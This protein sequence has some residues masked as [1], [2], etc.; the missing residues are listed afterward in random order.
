MSLRETLAG[1]IVNIGL[2]GVITEAENVARGMVESTANAAPISDQ[3]GGY[4]HPNL[5]HGKVTAALVK[6]KAARKDAKAPG[7]L[8]AKRILSPEARRRIQDAQKRRWDKEKGRTDGETAPV[9]EQAPVE[10]APRLG[11]GDFL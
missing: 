2:R 8:K 7:D 5:T 3:S 4:D 11:P 1:A 9:V 10:E 6:I